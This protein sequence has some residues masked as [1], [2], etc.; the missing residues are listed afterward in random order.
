[1]VTVLDKKISNAL[2]AERRRLRKQYETL[3]NMLKYMD[4][5]DIEKVL[6]RQHSTNEQIEKIDYVMSQLN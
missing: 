3:D 4:I 1:M 2:I 5:E 6:A